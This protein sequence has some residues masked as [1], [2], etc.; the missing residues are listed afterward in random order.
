MKNR[1]CRA[2]WDSEKTG[3]NEHCPGN[4]AAGAHSL[5]DFGTDGTRIPAPA[6]AASRLGAGSLRAQRVSLA[7]WTLEVSMACAIVLPGLNPDAF[8]Y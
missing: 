8:S 6:G 1:D 3:G 4:Q 7:V 2:R 5:A